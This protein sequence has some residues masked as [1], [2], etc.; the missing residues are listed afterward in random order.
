MKLIANARRIPDSNAEVRLGWKKPI[1]LN[2]VRRDMGSWTGNS[3]FTNTKTRKPKDKENPKA[4]Y[5]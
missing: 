3:S 1:R 2:N 5:A 4:R